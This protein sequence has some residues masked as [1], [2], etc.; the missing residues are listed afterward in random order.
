MKADLDFDIVAHLG[1]LRNIDLL[2]KGIYIVQVKLYY[3]LNGRLI[4]PVGMFS[5]PSTV[6]SVVQSQT[7]MKYYLLGIFTIS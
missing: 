2:C 5:S 4:A 6:A 7:V 1:Y 3:G